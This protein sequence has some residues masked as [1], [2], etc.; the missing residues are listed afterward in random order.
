LVPCIGSSGM[1]HNGGLASYPLQVKSLRR[2][3]TQLAHLKATSVSARRTIYEIGVNRGPES[4]V[5]RRSFCQLQRCHRS[6]VYAGFKTRVPFPAEEN[7]C[8]KLGKKLGRN[9]SWLVWKAEQ[10]HCLH[11]YLS[12]LLKDSAIA[13]SAAIQEILSRES[14]PSGTSM[15]T[16]LES[17]ETSVHP[18]PGEEDSRSQ[19]S[20]DPGDRSGKGSRW[21]QMF[22][23]PERMV[24]LPFEGLSSAV[25]RLRSLN[26]GESLCMADFLD[27]CKSF[28]EI[29]ASMG[30]SMKLGRVDFENNIHKASAWLN[31]DPEAHKTLKGFLEAEQATGIH[32]PGGL[33]K[34]PSGAI[35]ILWIR[36][37]LDFVTAIFEEHLRSGM[38]LAHSA[39]KA[40]TKTLEP[41]HGRLLR[42]TFLVTLGRVPSFK[43]LASAS[44]ILEAEL[45][46]QL[47]SLCELLRPLCD[48]MLALSVE[49][50]MEDNRRV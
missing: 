41:C 28:V 24:V 36:R 25:S 10:L 11:V 34:D 20:E 23:P 32:R 39:K 6:L 44:G 4:W 1:L 45:R 9:S 46:Q 2:S 38:A 49:L 43:T 22:R 8:Q 16:T 40:Y 31:R 19:P 14:E 27:F 37:T 30:A 15:K 33:L 13:E 35:S 18:V 7:L 21:L 5:V 47:Q 29:L 50:D 12:T 42:S 3:E 26:N 17:R 48:S